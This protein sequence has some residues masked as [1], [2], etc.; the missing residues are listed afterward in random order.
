MTMKEIKDA[1]IAAVEQGNE[2]E[3]EAAAAQR[4]YE[5]D[6]RKASHALDFR[7]AAGA[8]KSLEAGR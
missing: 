7:S 3:R 5:K 8:E 6:G 4:Q 1:V 2:N